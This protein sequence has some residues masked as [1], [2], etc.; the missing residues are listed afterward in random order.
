[1]VT[2]Q[3][4]SR[5]RYKC[6]QTGVVLK[7]GR[8]DGYRRSRLR[9]LEL[10][11]KPIKVEEISKPRQIP[12]VVPNWKGEVFCPHCNQF[13]WNEPDPGEKMCRK[14]DG[15]FVISHYSMVM[16]SAP[17]EVETGFWRGRETV[18]CPSCG[19]HMESPGEGAVSGCIR[20]GRSLVQIPKRPE[21]PPRPRRASIERRGSE[22][23]WVFCPYC[24]RL[25]R[26][27]V[28]GLNKCVHCGN[29]YEVD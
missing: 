14:C 27:A 26:N 3:P 23:L 17:A 22:G 11:R 24:N 6:V 20:C 4:L 8:V 2:F 15:E 5:G 25:T 7:R 29:S 10:D 9:E 21:P 19:K 12:R 16:L 28:L 13:Y 18:T 1:M